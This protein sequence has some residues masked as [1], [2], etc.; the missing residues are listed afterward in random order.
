MS[1]VGTHDGGAVNRVDE[2]M[3]FVPL[4]GKF[5]GQQVCD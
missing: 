1:R 3:P 5:P 2:I 4:I